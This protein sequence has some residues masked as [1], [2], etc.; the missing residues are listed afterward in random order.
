MYNL[1]IIL[2]DINKIQVYD[3]INN[4]IKNKDRSKFCS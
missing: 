2:L 3:L 4:Y 1:Y